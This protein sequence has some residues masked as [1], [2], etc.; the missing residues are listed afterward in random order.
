VPAAS[1]ADLILPVPTEGSADVRAR[2]AKA[3]EVQRARFV[4]LGAKGV[5][6]NAE[7]SGRLLED[8]AAPDAEG[9]KLLRQAADTLQLS[10][11]GFHRVMRVA[12]TLADLDG[13]ANVGRLHIAEALSYRGETLRQRSA[14]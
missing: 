13:E 3:R 1:A 9:A 4:A 12:R 7:C 11:R 2:V 14:A 10:A 8:I 5:R 6:T